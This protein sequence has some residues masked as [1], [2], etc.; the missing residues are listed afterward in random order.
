VFLPNSFTPDADGLNDILLPMGY[1][2]KDTNLSIYDRWGN[3]LF[4]SSDSAI[5]WD[6]KYK[7]RVCEQG[8]YVYRLKAT[9][10][11]GH[12]SFRVGHVTLLLNQKK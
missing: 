5:G 7:G 1:G 12:E 4:E 3:L 11:Q 6:G 9:A 10:L 2:L 8:V